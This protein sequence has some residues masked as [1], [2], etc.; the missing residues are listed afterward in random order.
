MLVV[1]TGVVAKLLA[2]NLRSKSVRW[3]AERR[4]AVQVVYEHPVSRIGA[5][6]KI[7]A[8]FATRDARSSYDLAPLVRT[9][10][11]FT[12]EERA[13]F[14]AVDAAMHRVIEQAADDISIQ[15]AARALT[16]ED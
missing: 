2:E 1:E 7:D 4:A 3:A 11:L 14:V 5:P 6:L 9:S 10:V 16:G 12:E 15:I 8:Q 13:A